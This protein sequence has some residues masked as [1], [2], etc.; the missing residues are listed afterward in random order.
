[1]G[2]RGL[3]LR[4]TFIT[5]ATIGVVGFGS[6]IFG[7]T[8]HAET[9]ED[10]QDQRSEVKGN[11]SDADAKIADVLF[12]LEEINEQISRVES[13]L[14]ENKAQMKDT[15]EKI[16]NKNDEI[17]KLE[18][19]IAGLEEKIEKRYQILKERAISYQKSGGDI[20]YL[21]VV[22]GSSNFSELVSRVS[23]VTKI[24]D[25]DEE[26]MKKQEKDKEEVE[27]KQTKAEEKLA[28]LKDME[29]EYEAIQETTLAQKEAKKSSKEELKEKENNLSDMKEELEIK[30][31]ELASLESDVQESIETAR[32]ERQERLTAANTTNDTNNA[33]TE[34][35]SDSNAKSTSDSGAELTTLSDTS[36]TSG[37]GSVIN[38]GK[39]FIGQST[40]VF[41]AKDPGSGQFD[42]SGFVSWAYEEEG[43][44]IPR[45]TDGL[46]STGSEVSPDN[47]QP[48]DLVFFDTYKKNGHVGIY[49]GNGQFI[50]SQTST[51]V[52]I[53]SM[54]N[55][56]WKEHFSGHV[57]RVK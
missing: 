46:A 25:S 50:G 7:N 23:A 4:K 17:E 32:Q 14:K 34:S 27:N 30:D 19:E 9:L 37:N 35:N 51:G 57:R 20:D 55:T 52:D 16:G 2:E 5:L 33:G 22:L 45:S 48:G 44:S 53:A 38:V 31:S 10:I 39:Q 29:S 13:T 6:A 26:L 47:M 28:T 43:Y 21:E 18:D 56:Y 24:T 3:K 49:M 1:M 41:G 54:N 40:Y 15:K 8:V 36:T 12:D 42:C 11:L